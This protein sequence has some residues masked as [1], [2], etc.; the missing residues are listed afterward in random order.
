M[1]NLLIVEDSLIQSHFLINSICREFQNVKLYGV[2]TTGIE[3]IDII[4]EEK[5]DLIILDLKLS[6]IL[7][8]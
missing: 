3:A 8:I 2:V 6:M 1:N 7:M 5:V 4:K